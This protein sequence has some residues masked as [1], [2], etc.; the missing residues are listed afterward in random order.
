MCESQPLTDHSKE[1]RWKRHC[2]PMTRLTPSLSPE[3]VPSKASPLMP[4][5][6]P[7]PLR[8]PNNVIAV[9]RDLRVYSC[10]TSPAIALATPHVPDETD[11]SQPGQQHLHLSSEFLALRRDVN[12]VTADGFVA[13]AIDLEKLRD[14]G[15][16]TAEYD[17]RNRLRRGAGWKTETE[18]LE[19]RP[20]IL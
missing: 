7:Y 19:E 9:D 8:K 11:N 2:I 18:A 14:L 6:Q 10:P 12:K 4:G 16:W 3:H 15:V 5:L 1:C 17:V 20:E 13:I